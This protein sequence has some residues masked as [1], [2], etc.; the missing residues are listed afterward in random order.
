MATN[1]DVITEAFRKS[2]IINPRET[3]GASKGADGLELLNDMMSDW[4]DDGIELGYYPQTSLSGTIPIEDK[5][6]RGVKYNLSR[7]I[8]ADYGVDLPAETVRIAELTLARL[9]KATTEEFS[10]DFS[11]MPLG[12]SNGF[13][14][15]NG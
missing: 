2:G 9:E 4:E 5:H 1:L 13:N 15:N 12:R 11:H 7:A 6:L 14:I 8:A 3:P 10:T